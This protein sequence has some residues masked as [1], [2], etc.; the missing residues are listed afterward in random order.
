MPRVAVIGL[1]YW[2]PNLVRNFAAVL[3]PDLRMVCDLCPDRRSSITRNYPTVQAV[4]DTQ[5]VFN[6]PDIDAV[7]IATP[8]STHFPL[9]KAALL[10][11]KSV[12]VEKPLTRTSAEAEELIDI[13]KRNGLVLMVDHV[14]LHNNAVKKMRQMVVDGDLGT[15]Q[16]IDSVRINLGLIQ[17]D[18][19][20]VWDLAPH[21]LSIVDYI[22]G[23]LPLSVSAF[24]ASHTDQGLEDV[25]Y[26]TL[27]YGAG[28]IAN[29]HVNWLSP[30]K[31]R[32]TTVGGS[33][34]SI[35]YND[36]HKAEILKV[37]D[38][39]VHVR[40]QDI[41]DR[42][43]VL[44]DYR[45]GDVYS[46]HIPHCEPLRNA[47]TEFLHCIA[48]G[49]RPLTDGENGLCVVRIL[50]AAQKSIQAQGERIALQTPAAAGR[51]L[52]PVSSLVSSFD[53]TCQLPV[54]GSTSTS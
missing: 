23:R 28:L 30:V 11:G 33:K 31:I 14:F 52:F 40:R 41:E 42:R 37:Y 53:L 12:F 48:T 50:E 6:N 16:Y 43:R 17:N 49:D 47:V 7:A 4:A 35:V 44:V 18:I 27:D 29:F 32:Y 5:E 1:G 8:V 25:A 51:P 36:L 10:A 46:P 45:V 38:S 13:A 19:N 21:D 34:K 2:G 3:G 24:G 20:V 54:S 39:G 22:V 15:L 9:A 26:L